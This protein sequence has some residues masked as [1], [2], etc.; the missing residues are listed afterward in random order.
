VLAP[1]STAAARRARHHSPCTYFC[2]HAGG[3]GGSPGVPPCKVVSSVIRV[4]AG[5]ATVAVRCAGRRTSRGAVVIYPHDF[6]HNYVNDGV[7]AGSYDGADL[8]AP[9]HR[10][11]T[12]KILLSRKAQALLSRKH[13]LRVDVL[14]ELNTKPAV[15][16][17]TRSNLPLVQVG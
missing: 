3:L 5:I 4:K 6:A 8:L 13:S 14:I 16:A 17:T 15:Q 10:T 2:K 1:L 7:P 12:L 11:V 9:P